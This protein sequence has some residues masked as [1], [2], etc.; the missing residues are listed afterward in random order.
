MNRI[1]YILASAFLLIIAPWAFTQGA[2]AEAIIRI[3][4]KNLA[5][6]D[7]VAI[8]Y[9]KNTRTDGSVQEYKM[10][11]K[12]KNIDLIHTYF[13]EPAREKGREMLRNGDSIWTY[14]PDLGRSMKVEDKESF[15]GSDFSNADV[16]RVDWLSKYNA[17]LLKE[18]PNQ[19]IIDLIAKTNY[20]PYAQM[21]IWVDKKNN[22]PIKQVFF[23][24]NGTQLKECLYGSVKQF[25]SVTRP[26]RMVMRN[27]ATGQVS[28]MQV[29]SMTLNANLPDS[30]FATGNLGK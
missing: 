7:I 16:L 24:S 23:D 30:R 22:M 14:L 5:P 15:A 11:V 9:I 6:S 1:K 25:G 12:V 28:E 17:T 19:W 3:I 20:A 26:T 4:E 18:T 8:Y 13:L 21:R 29:L 10:E 2:D 27:I